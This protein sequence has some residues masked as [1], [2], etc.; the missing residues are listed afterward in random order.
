MSDPVF[1]PDVRFVCPFCGLSV[2]AGHDPTDGEPV[3]FHE[4]PTCSKF[5]ALEIDR[6]L[7]ACRKAFQATAPS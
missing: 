3:V 5:E 6:Y 1:K 2:E 7:E 4:E